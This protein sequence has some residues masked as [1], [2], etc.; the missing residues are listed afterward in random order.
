VSARAVVRESFYMHD[1]LRKFDVTEVC[2]THVV[3]VCARERESTARRRQEEH[4]GAAP[5][6]YSRRGG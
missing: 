3:C 6:I 5:E 2:I 4:A 1:Y